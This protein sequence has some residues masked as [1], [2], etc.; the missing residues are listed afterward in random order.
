MRV[1]HL[2]S[3]TGFHGA[4]TMAAELIRHSKP[5][6]IECHVGV[7]DNGG[8]GD[9]QV[10]RAVQ[11]EAQ[12]WVVPGAGRLNSSAIGAIAQ[13]IAHHRIQIVHSHK[14][15]TTFHALCARQR[16]RFKL[17]TTYHNW[18]IETRSLELYAALDK[19]IARFCDAAIGVSA[20]VVAEL[21]RFVPDAKL[22][23]IGNGVDTRRF[24]PI[25]AR[26]VARR[27]VGLGA[28]PVVGFVGRL[29]RQKAVGDFLDAV[30]RLRGRM[31]VDAVIVGDGECRTELETHARRADIADHV[32]FLGTRADLPELY[33]AM[34]LFVLPSR[35]EAS[36][37][38]LLEAMACGVPVIGTNAG[39]IPRIVTPGKTGWIIA[40]G[41]PID[42]AEA[43]AAALHD[44]PGLR[45]MGR[46]ARE[47]VVR[48]HSARRMAEKYAAR[49]SALCQC[50][51]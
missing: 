10:L 29:S 13:Y 36:P 4:E 9:R 34:D 38:A 24:A 46:D 37:M 5:L 16:Q 7:F 30:A 25:V 20:E 44:P 11:D 12:S 32:H 45:Q 39:D 49:Y 48:G 21:A 3:S 23:H 42:L 8:C 2:L 40:A 28:R 35:V 19:R 51:M 31:E 47:A 26:D 27:A 17:L 43:I 15:K 33:C 22:G 6:G 18:L 50:P 14:Y 41:R 1:L